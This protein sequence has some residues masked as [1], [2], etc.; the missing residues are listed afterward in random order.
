MTQQELIDSLPQHL[1]PFVKRQNYEQYTP[2]D[3]AVWRF[4]M[5]ELTD[6]LAESAHP[7]YLEGLAKTGISL[8]H[9]PS[10]EEMND[11]LSDFDWRAVVVDGSSRPLFSWSFSSEDSG[12]CSGHAQC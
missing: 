6:Q 3:Q 8:D 9:I 10:I 7:V 5:S 12:H 1:R 2:Q 11:C 4:I